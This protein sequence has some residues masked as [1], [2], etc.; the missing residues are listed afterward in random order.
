VA[1]L[2]RRTHHS[3]VLYLS[4]EGHGLITQDEVTNIEDVLVR[5]KHVQLNSRIPSCELQCYQDSSRC[6]SHIASLGEN[7]V[8][9]NAYHAG[10]LSEESCATGA[11]EA[12]TW[13]KGRSIGSVV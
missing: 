12:T 2:G 10:Q 4:G 9:T 7:V 6:A 13:G 3:I 8:P 11:I 5:V 1:I